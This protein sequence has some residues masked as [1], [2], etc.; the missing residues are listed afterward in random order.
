MGLTSIMVSSYYPDKQMITELSRRLTDLSDPTRGRILMVLDGQELSVAELQDSLLLPQSTVSRHLKTLGRGDWVT[1]RTEGPSQ[2]YRFSGREMSAENRRLWQVVREQL[3][4]APET[5]SDRERVK[6]VLAR[7]HERSRAFF[8]SEAGQWDR[9]RAELFGHR[10]E[11]QALLGLTD[12]DWV[13]GD[14]GCGTGHLA[15]AFSPFV[16][17]VIAVDESSAMLET[18]RARA[19]R[20]E[21]LEFRQG[22]LELLPIAESELDLAIMALVLPYVPEPGR[23]LAEAARALKPDGRILVVDLLPHD[24]VE[25][26]E[27]LG[28]L[29]RGI[30][31]TQLLEWL[32]AAGLI[33][34]RV[35]PIGAGTGSR[36]P[37][38]FVASARKQR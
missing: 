12:P 30:G 38:L 19:T 34:A 6:A 25:Y 31:E 28:H 14:L 2:K 29:R 35:V 18:A 15:L 11:L 32:Q 37:D 22:E 3:V 7:R 33:D 9:Y 27:T 24:R 20:V 23:V 4:A 13:V 5:R 16:R 21:N 10:F 36:G 8:A 17:Q 26:E 1:A